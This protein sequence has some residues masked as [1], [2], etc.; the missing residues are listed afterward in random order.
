MGRNVSVEGY[1]EVSLQK[2]CLRKGI[3]LHELMHTL[4]FYHEQ[5]RY[6]RDKYVEIF[7][8]NIIDGK[9]LIHYTGSVSKNES[10]GNV[11]VKELVTD[12]LKPVFTKG[13]TVSVCKSD[14]CIK[15]NSG[16]L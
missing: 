9:Q 4:G 8:E 15:K 2:G 13:L 12:L 16:Q 14:K 5:G 1:Q 7:W 10:C 3:I 11:L 6:D